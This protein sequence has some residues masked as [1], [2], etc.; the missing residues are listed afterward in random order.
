MSHDRL[1]GVC[2]ILHSKPGIRALTMKFLYRLLPVLLALVCPIAA[3]AGDLPYD[4]KANATE[5]VRRALQ[6][7]RESHKDVLLVFGANWCPDCR[8]LDLALHGKDAQTL[9]ARF[10]IVKIDV[11]QFDRNIDLAK[12]YEVP[13][14]KGIPAAA[15]VSADDRLRVVTR[16]GELANARSMGDL[17][18]VDFLSKLG[19]I[20]AAKQ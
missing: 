6:D 3:H 9:A 13:L 5:D 19:G 7:A 10:E 15:V 11:G 20:S 8:A 1:A 14:R 18:I 16:T 4:E 17:A 2:E 12:R